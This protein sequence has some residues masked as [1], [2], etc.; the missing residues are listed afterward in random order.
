LWGAGNSYL[1]AYR[2][3][4]KPRR[5]DPLLRS[6]PA[7]GDF[8]ALASCA[9]C[10]AGPAVEEID[11]HEA[12]GIAVCLD[13]LARYTDRYRR[14]GLAAQ[15]RPDGSGLPV[16]WEEASLARALGRTPIADTAQD[17]SA[18]A[19]LG[20]PDTQRNHVATLYADGNAIGALFD[21]IAAHGDPALKA[22]ISAEVSRVT[23]DALRE[24]TRAVLGEQERCI[25][26]IPHVVGGD[27]LVVSVVAD[28][29]WRF[30]MAYLD[31]F[32]RR[33]GSIPGVPGGLI[34]AVAPTASAGLVF[35]HCKFPFQ[36]AAE[37][38]G[39]RLRTAKR[40]YHGT[41]P[42]VAWLDVTRDGEH[43]PAGQRA[44][45]LDHLIELDDPLRA[46]AGVEPSGRAVL[47]RLADPASPLVS[48]ARLQE[49]T[50]RLDRSAV[51]AP[52]L[53]DPDPAARTARVAGALSAA[54][55]WR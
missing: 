50:R 25:P 9:E 5:E 41:A 51:L 45:S 38:A 4:M 32:R 44:W 21:R 17:F 18:L 7:P 55:W 20:G 26:V 46:L 37:L 16:Y 3:S 22:R 48:V 43:P 24:A 33:L 27:D 36:R 14:Q 49:H 28:R 13:C 8:P 30:T 19:A 35:A 40:Q 1:E 34:S 10:R 11:I 54:R 31:E 6:L 29:A 53:S 12:T 23:R 42:A 52:F 47:E 39:E 15:L 2:D